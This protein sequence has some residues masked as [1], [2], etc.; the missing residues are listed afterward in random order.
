MATLAR[1]RDNQRRCRARKR[2]Y[3][4]E[5]EKKIRDLQDSEVQTNI[6]NYQSTVQRLEAENG[7]LRA[8]LGQAG[9]SQSEVEAQLQDGRYV[10][11]LEDGSK[12]TEIQGS[13]YVGDNVNEFLEPSHNEVVSQVR[14]VNPPEILEY[15]VRHLLIYTSLRICFQTRTARKT[16]M[17]C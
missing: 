14:Y 16:L 1:V 6:E 15:T 2:E 7:I 3:V 11:S 9:F 5:L 4:V 8:L 13:S 10:G 12:N 17:N